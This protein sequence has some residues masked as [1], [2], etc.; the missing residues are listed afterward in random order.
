MPIALVKDTC[1][2]NN[3]WLISVMFL[4]GTCFYTKFCFLVTFVAA[5]CMGLGLYS[6]TATIVVSIMVQ[7]LHVRNPAVINGGDS[8][9]R[10]V[11]IY[12]MFAPRIADAFS[13]DA[14]LA[15]GC[16]LTAAVPPPKDG[17]GAK[18]GA[19]RTDGAAAPHSLRHPEHLLD[20]SATTNVASGSARRTVLSCA[21]AAVM[22]QVAVCYLGT[23]VNKL[24]RNG[25]EEWGWTM[26][27]AVP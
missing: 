20:M 12:L 1:F 21:T 18:K 8:I 10:L 15:N 17:K 16:R 11:S 5:V 14:I 6:R 7:S 26:L 27:T 4:S 23:G 19:E 24:W 22:L 25:G 13:V 3:P 2:F 9:L